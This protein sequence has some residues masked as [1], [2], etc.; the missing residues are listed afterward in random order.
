MYFSH[1]INNPNK[2]VIN[3]INDYYVIPFGHRCTSAIVLQIA[4]IRK[5]SLPFDWT[6]PLFP[7][8]I[9]NILENDFRD[10]IPDVHNNIFENKYN[11]SLAHFNININEGIREYIRRISRF[12]KIIKED[13]RIYFLYVNEDYL[14]DNKYRETEF[15]NTIFKEMLN[16]ELYL[17]NKYP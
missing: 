12:K 17:D 13:K 10:F 11:I 3:D 8:K 16:L 6:I 7:N 1:S 5:F 4:N 14:Y 2:I 9:K 15:N